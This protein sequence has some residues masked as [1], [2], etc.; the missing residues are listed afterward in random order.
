M[1]SAGHT[2]AHNKK[3][4]HIILPAAAS[5]NTPCVSRF[6]WWFVS[7]PLAGRSNDCLSSICSFQIFYLSASL[8]RISCHK[9]I[10]IFPCFQGY[11]FAPSIKI[12]NLQNIE[13]L[14]MCILSQKI[15]NF[16]LWKSGINRFCFFLLFFPES[17]RRYALIQ[18]KCPGKIILAGK[19]R[20]G[21]HLF[22][23]M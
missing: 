8:V 10:I 14:F 21:R 23:G 2:S 20:H 17:R 18:L 6:L 15:P 22:N 3:V 11:F 19:A 4:L 16:H 12:A 7:S 9:T 1:Q 13:R 5:D